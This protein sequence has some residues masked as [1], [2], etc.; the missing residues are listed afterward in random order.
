MIKS[1]KGLVPTTIWKFVFSSERQFSTQ[2][3]TQKHHHIIQWETNT[4][5]PLQNHD[6]VLTFALIEWI[7]KRTYTL[8]M[9]NIMRWR[10]YQAL[11]LYFT[12][13][14][15]NY[16]LEFMHKR[17]RISSFKGRQTEMVTTPNDKRLCWLW[18]PKL[19]V[20]ETFVAWEKT[21]K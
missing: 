7:C 20:K 3:D 16:T 10:R 17:R 13:I 5:T 18:S 9:T 11:G 4:K 1:S 8:T 19:M 12:I 14:E 6:L 21:V 15:R 2:N